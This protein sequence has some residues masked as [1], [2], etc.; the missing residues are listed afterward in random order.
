VKR[1]FLV[2]IGAAK[3][4]LDITTPYFVV[5]D[6]TQW[7]LDEARKRGVR[8]R[9][10]VEGDRTDAKTVKWA[11]RSNYDALLEEGIELYEYQPTMIHAKTTVVDGRWSIIGSA[12]FDNR[13]FDMNDEVN[14][15]ISDPSFAAVLTETFEDDL[16][17]AKRL[18][19]EEWR[20][21]A[22]HE[23]VNEKFWSLLSE[24]F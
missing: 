15:G 9:I 8:I 3:R 1:L 12:N 24:F 4:T 23:K 19:L 2:S 22:L 20:R 18:T 5:D 10:L 21:R 13:S 16:R 6:S 11:S 14:V 17:S 7:S